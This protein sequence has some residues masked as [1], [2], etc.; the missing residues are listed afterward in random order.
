MGWRWLTSSLIVL[1]VAGV[2]CGDDE[3]SGPSED[4]ITGT[5]L[6]TKVEYTNPE[7]GP[8]VD[9]IALGGSASLILNPDNSLAYTVT[10]SGGAADVTEGTWQLGGQVM[11]ITPAGMPFSWQFEVDFSGDG[12]RMSGANVEF[13][14]DDDDI[15]EP[16]E[17][18]LEFTR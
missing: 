7:V 10:P 9:L 1:A 8:A 2:G 18:N 5:W 15:D 11:T 14:L 6:A 17:L 16:A 4:E 3:P 13:D 12:L